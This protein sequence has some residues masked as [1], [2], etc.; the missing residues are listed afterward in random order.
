MCDATV[1]VTALSGGVPW[2]VIVDLKGG[3]IDP[4]QFGA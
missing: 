1:S 2:P 3:Y 4:R